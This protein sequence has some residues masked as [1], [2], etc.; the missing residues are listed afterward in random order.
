MLTARCLSRALT[1]PQP[2][3][4]RQAAALYS[5]RSGLQ[6]DGLGGWYNERLRA[7]TILSVKKDD[8]LVSGCVSELCCA[9]SGHWLRTSCR[10]AQ[11]RR[12]HDLGRCPA[13]SRVGMWP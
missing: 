12:R 3:Q 4:L 13:R 11:R 6:H 9:G 10:R 5:R 2:A 8:K 1:R 7:T